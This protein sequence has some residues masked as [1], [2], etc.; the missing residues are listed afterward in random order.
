MGLASPPKETTTVNERPNLP[1]KVKVKIYYGKKIVRIWTGEKNFNA[2]I[3]YTKCKKE[4]SEIKALMELIKGGGVAEVTA[5]EE[6][7][8]KMRNVTLEHCLGGQE[9]TRRKKTPK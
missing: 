2:P 4:E 5:T 9:T 8:I 6:E 1:V 3:Y 7:N